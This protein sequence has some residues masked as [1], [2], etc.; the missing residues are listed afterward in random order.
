MT[1]NIVYP[2]SAHSRAEVSAHLIRLSRDDRRLRFGVPSSDESIAGYVAGID[3]S[4]DTVFG[5]RDD[6]GQLIGLTHVAGVDDTAELGLSVDASMRGQGLAQAMF[7][8]AMLHAR[9]RGFRVLYMHC[10]SENAAM[11]HIAGKAGMRIV[12]DGSERDAHLALPP[13]TPISV[14]AEVYEG[15][16]VLLDWTLRSVRAPAFATP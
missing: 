2:L 8:R 4:A 14:G 10:L 11:M 5:V 6:D 3:F 13:A 15:Q 1:T 9:N 12:I 16:L 7:R